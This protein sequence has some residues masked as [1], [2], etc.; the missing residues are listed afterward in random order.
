MIARVR[1]ERQTKPLRMQTHSPI[2]VIFDMDGVL[3]DSAQPHYESWR[4]VAA[5]QGVDLRR[6][7]L[8]DLTIERLTAFAA[9]K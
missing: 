8:T 4:T 1:V 3:V 2:G 9:D 6:E 7:R 5:E